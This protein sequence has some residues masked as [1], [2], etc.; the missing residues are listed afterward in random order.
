MKVSSR[1][2]RFLLASF[3]FLHAAKS[4]NNLILQMD[5]GTP[6]RVVLNDKVYNDSA[7]AQI[8]INDVAKDTLFL[9]VELSPSL[10]YGITVFLLDKGKKTRGKEFNYLLRKEKNRL[11][12]VFMGMNDV[13]VPDPK[14][15]PRK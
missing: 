2:F 1:S 14:N 6:F 13:S 7:Q 12:P 4:Q 11:Q 15:L 9:K 10:S 3:L 5:D 8:Q